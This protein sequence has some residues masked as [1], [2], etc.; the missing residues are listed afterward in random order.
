MGVSAGDPTACEGSSPAGTR[1]RSA[2]LESFDALILCGHSPT[3]PLPQYDSEGHGGCKPSK[4]PST[5]R[6]AI[7]PQTLTLGFKVGGGQL[8]L[9]MLAC[10]KG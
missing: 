9:H 1:R 10:M 7:L 8:E 5:P 4:A 3:G 6:H 2:E